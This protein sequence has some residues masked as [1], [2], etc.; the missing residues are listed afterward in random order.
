MTN[1][2]RVTHAVRGY[3]MKF[4]QVE[5]ARLLHCSFVW[6]NDEKT[7]FRDAT[8]QE[9]AQMRKEQVK[10]Q[11]P[12]PFAE[13]PGLIFKPAQKDQASTRISYALLKQANV[14]AQESAA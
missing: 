2:S 5:K 9:A 6:M 11:E 3:T 14:F 1:N 10:L 7:L 8:I 4:G 12:I 13:L